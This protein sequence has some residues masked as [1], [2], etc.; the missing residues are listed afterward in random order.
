MKDLNGI[1]TKVKNV[2]LVSP[3]FDDAIFSAGGL[4]NKLTSTKSVTLI[5]VFTSAG[6]SS[7]TFSS[8]KM[9]KTIGFN[10]GSEM[11][12]QRV[13]EDGFAAKTAGISRILNLGFV[14]ALWREKR[15]SILG[16]YIPEI[17]R[18]YPTYRYHI[19]KGKVSKHDKITTADISKKL[20][21]IIVEEDAV[22]LCPMGFGG[23]VD[24]LVVRNACHQS[25]DHSRIIYW[26]DY[27]YIVSD[28]PAEP[29]EDKDLKVAIAHVDNKIKRKISLLY[30][31]QYE[32]VIGENAFPSIERYYVHKD[33]NKA[34]FP[35]LIDGRYQFVKIFNPE[36]SFSKYKFAV[37][38]DTDGEKYFA[39][40]FSGSTQ[41]REY[42][43]LKNEVSCCEF[44]KDN[45][46][47]SGIY[48]PEVVYKKLS[49]NEIL[50]LTKFIEGRTLSSL[51]SKRKVVI[52][53]KVANYLCSV[54]MDYLKARKYKIMSRS[55]WFWV[56]VLVY[57]YCM[58]FLKK[59]AYSGQIKKVSIIVIK[60]LVFLLSRKET[61]LIHRDFN[62]FNIMISGYKITLIDFQLSCV[63]DPLLERAIMLLKYAKHTKML[64][65]LLKTYE[66]KKILS[67][68]KNKNALLA[69]LGIIT[70]YDFFLVDGDSS[71]SVP[72][73]A[74][75]LKYSKTW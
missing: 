27:P 56:M 60:R 65:E 61:A 59:S 25:F 5:N 36:D 4:I 35:D 40:K 22:I 39:K 45:P 8:R 57:S 52:F 58:N 30:K 54:N 24:H 67:N 16:K 41:K 32:S 13:V 19:I 63:A 71:Y 10:T 75:I 12:K 26:S 31:T 1:L 73:L 17:D 18:I 20:K 14:D 70:V 49:K 9:I 34:G 44:L 43:F 51:G 47:T 38:Q 68:K 37:Y 3:H 28:Q 69:Y 33:S 72:S 64:K 42:K 55:K 11:Y 62:D 48:V 74:N 50:V 53:D 6:N 29:V 46:T 15:N 23:H 66:F 21:Q 7:E 2:Y